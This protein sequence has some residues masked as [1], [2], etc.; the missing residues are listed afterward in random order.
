MGLLKKTL[1]FW[2][3]QRFLHMQ[4]LDSPIQK[5]NL[6]HL[7]H[8]NIMKSHN[9][10]NKSARQIMATNPSGTAEEDQNLTVRFSAWV[11][12]TLSCVPFWSSKWKK[13]VARLE[14]A[15]RRTMK[16]I[17]GWTMGT[18]K[19]NWE[20]FP[21]EKKPQGQPHQK[22]W[23]EGGWRF[24]LP[25]GATWRIQGWQVATGEGYKKEI[26]LEWEQPFMGRTSP[27]GWCG[28][29]QGR[30]S[31]GD[32]AGCGINSSWLPFSC[33]VGP[34]LS[35]KVTSSLGCWF[36][37]LHSLLEGI[38]YLT[39]A[40]DDGDNPGRVIFAKGNSNY[41]FMATSGCYLA[42]SLHCP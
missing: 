4:A 19:K 28:P 25:Q 10:N 24:S 36:Y 2:A 38:R 32:W 1:N 26:L 12:E 39:L 13:E 23:S 8:E 27:E 18:V 31:R 30:F 22:E 21:G 40:I 29:Y 3:D 34:N 33:K 11:Q 6:I 9:F 41:Q 15:T 14:K 5:Q 7:W 16:I 35:F 42:L 37:E 17:R 20:F